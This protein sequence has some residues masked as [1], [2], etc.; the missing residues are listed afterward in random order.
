MAAMAR[1]SPAAQ[2]DWVKVGALMR[3]GIYNP[4]DGLE[5]IVHN[6]SDLL[7]PSKMVGGGEHFDRAF[8]SLSDHQSPTGC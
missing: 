3:A 1:S 6:K 4:R 2:S 8:S 7:M 5:M